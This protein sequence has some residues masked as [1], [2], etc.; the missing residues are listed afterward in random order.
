MVEAPYAIDSQIISEQN[1][2]SPKGIDIDK[3]VNVKR[4]IIT[5]PEGK[6]SV[7]EIK[8]PFGKEQKGLQG[9]TVP[10]TNI[11]N[12]NK[13]LIYPEYLSSKHK[14]L[15]TRWHEA[16]HERYD[17][18][19]WNNLVEIYHKNSSLQSVL[20]EHADN[21]IEYANRI[22][23]D[24]QFSQST[25]ASIDT[26]GDL[27]KRLEDY[28]LQREPEKVV[29]YKINAIRDVANYTAGKALELGLDVSQDYREEL[30]LLKQD[31]LPSYV[32]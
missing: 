11:L 30:K 29:E 19:F 24:K 7:T 10:G 21:I 8:Q 27:D 32:V 2:Y 17:N 20:Q 18:S 23:T 16:N 15:H 13:D 22:V 25:G 4:R 1:V 31:K 12:I 28:I 26:A 14:D 6:K 9:F 3:D 5:T